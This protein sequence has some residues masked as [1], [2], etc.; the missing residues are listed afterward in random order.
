MSCRTRNHSYQPKSPI[1]TRPF[2]K[3][4]HRLSHW[5]KLIRARVMSSCLCKP[6]LIFWSSG[7][8][9][10]RTICLQLSPSSAVLLSE[11]PEWS[12]LSPQNPSPWNQSQ[13]FRQISIPGRSGTVLPPLGRSVA[14]HNLT[15]KVP[16][17]VLDH[18][19]KRVF[20]DYP[21]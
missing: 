19:A 4:I 17:T 11:G 8:Q 13:F 14:S 15:G 12:S 18:T 21:R 3:S 2:R 9:E 1:S 16:H 5:F 7:S 10:Y 6:E 20:D